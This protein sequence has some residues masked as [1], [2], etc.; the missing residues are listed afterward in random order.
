MRTNPRFVACVASL[1]AVVVC[2]AA[3]RATA[4]DWQ[5]TRD[6]EMVVPFGL[7]GG[8][9]LLA[10]TVI[11][12]IA[13]D[14]L[15][16]TTITAVNKPGGGTA[17]GVA[18]VDANKRG[19]PY[20]LVLIN[21]QMQLTPLRVKEAKGWR[22]LT[23]VASLMLDDYLFM[24]RNDSPY[25][26]AAALLAD[27]KGREPRSISIGSAGTADDMAI[28]VFE[29]GTGVTLNT[30]RFNSGGEILTALLGGHIDVGAGNPLEFMGQLSS[31]EVRALGVFRESRFDTLPDVMTMKEQG[32]KTAPFQMWRG[33]A[34]PGDAPPEA[35]AYWADVMQKVGASA[36]FK[37]Y[38]SD[39]V[40]TMHVLKAAEFTN[41]LETQ[42]ALY[43]DM[44]TRLG[45]L[46]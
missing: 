30:V 7:G 16:P 32:I 1:L 25:K 27:A 40:A 35:V 24:V 28:T 36:Q 22:D 13:E 46:K 20:T 37:K 38:I 21:P 31:G 41:F 3:P 15:V 14:K 44:L 17:V 4:A 33:I 10:R 8:A 18:Y 5:P 26:D 42:E 19:D 9:D 11:K 23:P 6:V 34:L 39:N 2:L 29:A 43:K 45:V 12:I